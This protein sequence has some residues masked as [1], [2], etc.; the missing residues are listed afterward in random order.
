MFRCIVN[1]HTVHSVCPGGVGL[2]AREA[3]P[4]SRTRR[5]LDIK[6]ISCILRDEE[7]AR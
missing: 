6:Q 3:A 1:G 4:I 5:L 2:L 7:V